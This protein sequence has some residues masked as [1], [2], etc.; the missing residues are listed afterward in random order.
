[1]GM[2]ERHRPDMI[3]PRTAAGN[4]A[5][6]DADELLSIRRPV[7]RAC[8][9]D[10]RLALSFGSNAHRS[11]IFRVEPG[12]FDAI[13]A[14]SQTVAFLPKRNWTR[15]HADMLI[16]GLRSGHWKGLAQGRES[17]IVSYTD[18]RLR[19]ER[20]EVEIGFCMTH[21]DWRRRGKLKRTLGLLV[22]MYFDWDFRIS[23]F[24][25]NLPMTSLLRQ[26]GFSLGQRLPDDRIDGDA[27]LYFARSAGTPFDLSA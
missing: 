18:Y 19:P 14:L 5:R 17:E 11:P 12:H 25:G 21:P 7:I 10:S 15:P 8:G 3:I 27:T 16:S 13:H 1:M 9:D 4:P 24:E 20:A 26:L 2:I 23:T 22:V 6:P